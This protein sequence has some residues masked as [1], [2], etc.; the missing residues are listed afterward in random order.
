MD[1]FPKSTPAQQQ[2]DPAL[3]AQAA[4]SAADLP[5]L[6]SYLVLRNGHLVHEYYA[7]D[8]TRS[9]KHHIRSITKSITSI[10]TGI[11]IDQGIIKHVDQRILDYFPQVPTDTI[12]SKVKDITLEHLL[13]MTSGFAWDEGSEEAVVEW[14]FGGKQVAITDSLTRSVE[15]EP[16]SHFNYDSPSADLLAT[17]LAIAMQNDLCRFAIQHL[18]NPLDI[19]DFEWERDPAGYYRGS[20]GLVMRPIDLA[21]IG[22]LTLQNGQW[23]EQQIV[24]KEWVEQSVVTQAIANQ[25]SGY[26]RLWWVK[27]NEPPRFYAAV[28]YGGQFITVAPE[29]QIIIVAIHEWWDL[30]SGSAGKQ[31]TDFNSQVLTK[32]LESAI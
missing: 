28:G 2:M 5:N 24:S 14:F 6:Y 7:Q 23:Q 1:Y 16:G 11:A 13:T 31:S 21:K 26:G 29:Q 3:F 27:E 12:D 30:P 15:H 20:A 10:L 9:T 8:N 19:H 4:K 17:L 18:F 22:Q 32:V 25:E